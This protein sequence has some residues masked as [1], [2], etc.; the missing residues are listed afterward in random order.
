M[1]TVFGRRQ[2]EDSK[3]LPIIVDLVFSDTAVME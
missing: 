2:P 3:W 1:K